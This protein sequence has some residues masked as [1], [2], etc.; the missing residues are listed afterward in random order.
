MDR[1]F[2]P[3]GTLP[4]GLMGLL[5]IKAEGFPQV[6]NGVVQPQLDLLSF[7]VA[8]NAIEQVS[9]TVAV[10]DLGTVNSGLGPLGREAWMI[11]GFVVE[12]DCSAGTASIRLRAAV[13]RT[14][15]AG[16]DHALVSD[17]EGFSSASDLTGRAQ[18]AVGTLNGPLIIG[19]GDVLG[20]LVKGLVTGP[21]NVSFAASIMRIPS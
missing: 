20:C 9:S 16:L 15:G 3:I 1:E 10:A 14:A 12:G 6:L 13:L 18:I 19:P 21:V 4:R 5:G 8:A 7:L 17:D 11:R 2:G